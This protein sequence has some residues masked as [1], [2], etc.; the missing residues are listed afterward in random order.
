MPNIWMTG[1][2]T[3]LHYQQRLKG[4]EMKREQHFYTVSLERNV[5]NIHWKELLMKIN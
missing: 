3:G 5:L 2:H 1:L 4:T